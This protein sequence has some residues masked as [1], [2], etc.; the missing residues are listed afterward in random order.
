M[1]AVVT[2]ESAGN[3]GQR[4][5]GRQQ[6]PPCAEHGR[7]S[8]TELP[9]FLLLECSLAQSCRAPLL[10]W[11]SL[12]RNVRIPWQRRSWVR[13][14]PQHQFLV[15]QQSPDTGSANLGDRSA[16]PVASEAESSSA[17]KSAEG[18]LAVARSLHKGTS[19][20]SLSCRREGNEIACPKDG[21]RA[22]QEQ[23]LSA[24]DVSGIRG[25]RS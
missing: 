5:T 4:I 19:M 6:I 3:S 16:D 22:P 23:A 25:Y 13:L 17:G 11:Y 24:Q 20:R 14:L 7:R 1:T 10:A 12:C 18:C 9:L 2:E 8:A 15:V 21:S